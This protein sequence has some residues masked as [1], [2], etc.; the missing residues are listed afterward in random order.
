LFKIWLKK[1]IRIKIIIN[2]WQKL[3][4]KVSAKESE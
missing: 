2:D 4:S 3:K 1:I